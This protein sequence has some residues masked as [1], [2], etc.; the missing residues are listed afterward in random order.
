V[1]H[2]EASRGR[3]LHS[4]HVFTHCFVYFVHYYVIYFLTA[5]VIS[6]SMFGLLLRRSFTEFQLLSYSEVVKLHVL[7]KKIS[8]NAVLKSPVCM[9]AEV[10]RS[11]M[12]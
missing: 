11:R 6:S 7:I 4:Y 10:R 8:S 12:E 9:K 2:N 1:G 5:G 3:N